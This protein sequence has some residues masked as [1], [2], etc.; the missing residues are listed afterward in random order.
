[1]AAASP[2]KAI[3][4]AFLEEEPFV[5]PVLAVTKAPTVVAGF[6]FGDGLH[7]GEDV[8]A[9]IRETGAQA[10]YAGSIG[11]SRRIPELIAGAIDFMVKEALPKA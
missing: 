11:A 4:V 3:D 6:F 9:A 1:M 10:I 8:P 7:A 5:E 2:F